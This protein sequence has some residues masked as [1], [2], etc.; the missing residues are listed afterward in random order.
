MTTQEVATKLHGAIMAFDIESIHRDLFAEGIESIE[1]GF[2]PL[3]YAKGIQ[4][5]EEKA[6]LF[7]GNLKELHQRTVS[8]SPMVSGNHI[9]LGMSFDATLQDD[10]RLK[11]S[12]LIVY[13]VQDGKIIKEQ[14][15]Y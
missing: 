2:T 8:D 3:P 5:V 11:V 14:I 10:S 1:P 9:S 15:F 6:K 13:E 4:Q 12:E 7:G